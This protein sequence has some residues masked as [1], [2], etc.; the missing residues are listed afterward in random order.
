[1]DDAGTLA[2]SREHAQQIFNSIA[3]QDTDGRL[4]WEL[5][6]PDTGNFTPFL[7]TEVR[8]DEEGILHHK[9]YRKEQKKN[10][11]LHYRSHHPMKT[12]ADVA[13]NFYKTAEKSSSPEYLEESWQIVDKLLRYNGYTLHRASTSTTATRLSRLKLV[14]MTLRWL[15]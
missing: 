6:F 9:F 5:D 11:T 14:T 10:I 13:K 2:R 8:V 15:V 4:A 3:V 12:K 7:G 1:M